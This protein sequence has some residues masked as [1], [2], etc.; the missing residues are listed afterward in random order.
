MSDV[1]KAKAILG[2]AIKEAIEEGEIP[3]DT[4]S[5]TS[6]VEVVFSEGVR[7]L[8]KIV[9]YDEEVLPTKTTEDLW[10]ILD[11]FPFA[12]FVWN[13][14]YA[15]EDWMSIVARARSWHDRMEYEMVKNRARRCATMH[16]SPQNYDQTI[17][18]IMDDKLIWLPIQRTKNYNGFAHQHYPVDN[19]DLNS[20]VYGVLAYNKEDAEAFRDASSYNQNKSVDHVTIGELL[21]FPDC[22]CD[23]FNRWWP[24]FVDPVYQMAEASPKKLW[25]GENYNALYVEPHIATH[26]MLRYAGFRLTSHFA[27]SLDCEKSKEVGQLWM[28][29]GREVDPR[30]LDALIQILSLPAE[31]SCLNGIAVVETE[32][33]TIVTNSMST[34]EKWAVRWQK[35]HK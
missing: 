3:G 5:A 27:C 17:E 8:G 7:E 9:D 6:N 31:W 20:S 30:G 25:I 26:Q 18:K 12:G 15:Q 35:V 11:I 23:A 34:K 19:L 10:P 21:G 28:D 32:P 29:V 24:Q 14:V 22:C 16:I 13:S 2:E 1:E 33:F 4:C